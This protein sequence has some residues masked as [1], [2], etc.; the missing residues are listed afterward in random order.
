MVLKQNSNDKINGIVFSISYFSSLPIRLDY[1]EANKKFYQGVLIGLPLVGIIL[2]SIIIFIYNILP[3]YSLYSGLLS[4]IIYVGLTGFLHFEAVADT[5]D[6][7]YASFSKKDIYAVMHEPQIGSIGVLG[8]VSFFLLEISALVYNLYLEQFSV[9]FLA[10]ILSRLSVYF[11]LNFE[12]HNK[13]HFIIGL[14]NSISINKILNIVF[15]PLKISVNFILNTLK[16]RLGFLNGDTLGF[17]IVTIE[18]IILNIGLLFSN[19]IY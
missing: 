5:I 16:N 13:S 1:F 14:K 9:I 3:F 17:L 8:V 18:I 15:Y 2:A 10:L 11:A 12:Y 4:A 7:W 19:N 6:G